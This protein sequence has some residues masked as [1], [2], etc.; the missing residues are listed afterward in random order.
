MGYLVAPHPFALRIASILRSTS[1]STPP[2]MSEIASR[3]LEDGT[4]ERLTQVQR[5][6]ARERY[7]ILDETLGGHVIWA[8]RLSLSAWLRVPEGWTEAAL[9]DVLRER[10]ILVTPSAPFCVGPES[11]QSGIRVCLA[12][13][14]S[15]QG[16][17]RSALGTIRE[18][19]RQLPTLEAAGHLM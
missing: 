17:L 2:A 15:S 6:E 16:A 1:W 9:V 5:K 19:L 8:H 4:A 7:A 13:R 10:R 11:A 18:T 12:G 3:L 14:V